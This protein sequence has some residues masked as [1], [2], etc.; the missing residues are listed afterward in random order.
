MHAVLDQ[1][2]REVHHVVVERDAH[3][4]FIGAGVW[5]PLAEAPESRVAFLSDHDR[6]RRHVVARLEV[7]GH[8]IM[9][10]FQSIVLFDFPKVRIKPPVVS[11]YI[12]GVARRVYKTGPR[13]LV[14]RAG[15]QT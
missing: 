2:H 7:P 8:K 3:P 1:R 6:R 15:L 4:I 14:Q 5:E 12:H 10:A 11:I 9:P 13:M